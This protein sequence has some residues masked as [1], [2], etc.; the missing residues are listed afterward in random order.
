MLLHMEHHFQK[1]ISKHAEEGMP[2]WRGR[3]EG[4]KNQSNQEDKDLRDFEIYI[5]TWR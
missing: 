2:L 3:A 5:H 1:I 4:E